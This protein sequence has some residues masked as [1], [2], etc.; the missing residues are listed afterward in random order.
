[1]EKF[2][3]ALF[4]RFEGCHI[5][6]TGAGCYEGER[7]FGNYKHDCQN[8][9]QLRSIQKNNAENAKGDVEREQRAQES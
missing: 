6:K 5:D 1:M 9:G 3:A 7:E 4:E 8:E 2:W